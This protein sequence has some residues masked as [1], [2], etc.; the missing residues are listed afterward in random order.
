MR[1]T[2]NL[3]RWPGKPPALLAAPALLPATSP[4]EA[5][6]ASDRGP[7]RPARASP[8]GKRLH[9]V[10]A[11][12]SAPDIVDIDG[13]GI[14]TAC[15]AT[16]G[17]ESVA[18]AVSHTGDARR[19]NHGPDTVSVV[20]SRGVPRVSRALQAGVAPRGIVFAERIT[21]ATSGARMARC[22]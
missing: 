6:I 16:V 18:V 19:V 5:G 21:Q 20:A 7:D 15:R 17:L 2:R 22:R 4:P 9:A 8:D 12:D 1:G 10:N 14:T 3:A 11:P 13:A